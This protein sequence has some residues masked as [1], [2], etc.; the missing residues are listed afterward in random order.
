MSKGDWYQ[1]YETILF[2][3]NHRYKNFYSATTFVNV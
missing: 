1:V 3:F 2:Q